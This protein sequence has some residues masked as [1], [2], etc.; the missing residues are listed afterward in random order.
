VRRGLGK[1]GEEG[2]G[3][4]LFEKG[5]RGSLGKRGSRWVKD[6]REDGYREKLLASLYEETGER[7]TLATRS[8]TFG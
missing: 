3:I 7:R 6:K 8:T 2:A 5:D 4:L 1:K